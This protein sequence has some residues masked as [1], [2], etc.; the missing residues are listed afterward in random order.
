MQLGLSSLWVIVSIML[1]GGLFGIVGMF[2]GVPLFAIIYTVTKR[3]IEHL[4]K[5]KGKSSNTRNYASK[6]NPLLK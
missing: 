2:L 1:F 6:S 4:L 3:I 5:M